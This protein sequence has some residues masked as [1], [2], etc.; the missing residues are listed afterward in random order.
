MNFFYQE[1]A[2]KW[3]QYSIFDQMANI[4][5]EI[6]RTIS[7]KKRGNKKFFLNAFYRALELIDFTIRDKKNKK[8]L[9]EI[10]RMREILADYLVGDNFY[11]STDKD[12]EKYFYPYMFAARKN[13]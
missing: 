13:K 2:K 1:T 3:F 4:G 11:R 10:L 12:W 9:K 8:Y 5:I 6:L 7:W